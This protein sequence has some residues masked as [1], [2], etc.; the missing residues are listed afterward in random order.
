MPF[1][2]DLRTNPASVPIMFLQQPLACKYSR[3]W[4]ARR[5]TGAVNPYNVAGFC[6]EWSMRLERSNLHQLYASAPVVRRTAT[7]RY[8]R[9]PYLPP[10][11]FGE[12]G[13]RIPIAPGNDVYTAVRQ[14]FEDLGLDQANVGSPAWN[15]LGDFLR[16]GQRALIKPNWVMHCNG[17]GGSSDA[18]ITHTAVI[19]SNHRLCAAGFERSRA[20]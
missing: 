12:H 13:S 11:R 6:G 16:P 15:P 10:R 4:S 3:S 8:P 18:L 19:L 1:V 2:C 5:S 17:G 20:D 9:F 14:V 7:G